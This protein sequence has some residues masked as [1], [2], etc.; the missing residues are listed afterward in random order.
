MN[1][2]RTAVALS[3]V[4]GL[5]ATVL[6][7][8]TNAAVTPAKPGDYN[9]D[10][11]PDLAIGAQFARPKPFTLRRDAGGVGLAY[12][13]KSVLGTKT[14]LLHRGLSWVPGP[15]SESVRFGNELAAGDLNG[16]GYSDLAVCSGNAGLILG[17]GGRTGLWRGFVPATSVIPSCR[18]M[19]VGDFNGDGYGDLVV[20]SS[21]DTSLRLYKGAT[22]GLPAKPDQVIQAGTFGSTALGDVNN[23]GFADLVASDHN[24]TRSGKS[25]AGM[26]RLWWGSAKG[27]DTARPTVD[28]AQDLAGVPGDVAAGDVF[29]VELALGDIDGDDHA[30]LA[31]TAYESVNNRKKAGT[32]TVVRGAESGWNLTNPSVLSQD[33]PGVPEDAEVEDRFG[34][35]LLLRDLDQDGR[36]E[37]I[38]GTPSD[39]VGSNAI[40]RPDAG[41]V[42][43]FRGSSAGVST[44][45]VRLITPTTVRMM[46]KD[47][48]LGTLDG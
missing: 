31:A 33:S 37:L 25:A 47:A 44:S 2:R 38:V 35:T 20:G 39:D 48:Q 45:G 26:V 17:F 5:L 4:A 23:D 12:G 32:V 40:V 29:G 13:G 42:T 10:G 16:D 36:T 28:L 8:S 27:I 41:T 22:N 18:T 14:Q 7:G 3:A 30:D 34:T 1:L 46:S 21:G 9:G 24:A 43:V 15:Q 6:V 11:Y 19:V